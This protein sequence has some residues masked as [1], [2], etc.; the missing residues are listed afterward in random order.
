MRNAISW[1]LFVLLVVPLLEVSR[2]LPTNWK[3]KLLSFG[4]TMVSKMPL[5]VD[6]I[7]FGHAVI[8]M[9]HVVKFDL[10]DQLSRPRTLSTSTAQSESRVGLD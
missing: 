10:I 8:I 1:K 3:T 5:I 9:V 4:S 7:S 6:H 2:N